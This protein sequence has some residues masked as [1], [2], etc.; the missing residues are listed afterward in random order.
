MMSSRLITD[1]GLRATPQGFDLDIRLPWYRS[2]PLSV[3]DVPE[4]K[5]DGQL[6]DRETIRFEING[7]SRTLDELY[8]IDDESWYVLDSAILHVDHA[9]VDSKSEHIIDLTVA[10]YPPYIKGFK[11]LTRQERKM[12]AL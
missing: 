10:L 11:R 6:I 7:Q 2:L 4:L 12:T 1:G 3:V 9:A 5:L 8:P